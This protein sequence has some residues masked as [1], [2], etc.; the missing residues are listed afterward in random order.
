MDAKS[1]EVGPNGPV[2]NDQKQQARHLVHWFQSEGRPFIE[3]YSP[4]QLPPLD[5]DL[6]RLENLLQTPETITVCFLGHSGVGKS[7]LL[8]ALAAG[9]DFILPA[10]GIGPLTALAT[11]VNYS[12]SPSF[13]VRYHKRGRL[14]RV[15]FAL[16]RTQEA[17][18]DAK[19]SDIPLEEL[20]EETRRELQNEI[21]AS[22]AAEQSQS[23]AN[24]YLKQAQ[25]IVTGD[26]FSNRPAE[27]LIDALRMAGGYKTKWGSA[28]EEGDSKR[29]DRVREALD[30]SEKDIPYERHEDQNHSSFAADLK[31][32][33]AGFLA[34]LIETIQVG[35]PADILKSGVILVDLPGVGIAKDSYRQ[36][37]QSYIRINARA[38]VLT[39]DKSGPTADAVELLRT[40]GYW[41]RLVGA[42]DDPNSDPCKLLIAVTKVDDVASAA[43]LDSSHV[44]P[45]IRPRKRDLYAQLVKDFKVGMKAQVADQLGGIAG[46][47]NLALEEARGKARE[48]ILENLEI[49]PIS[50][51]EYRKLLLD[52]ED[53]RPFLKSTEDTGIIELRRRLVHIAHEERHKLHIDIATVVD[54]LRE[55]ISGELKRLE[56]LWRNR[57][58]AAAITEALE[59][60]LEAFL[61]EKK[62]ERDVRLGGFREFL[63]TTS[64]T[65]IRYLV[66]QA[67]EAAEEDVNAFLKTLRNAHWATLR[68]AVTR[69]GTFVGSRAINLPE[70]IAQRF[71]EP[72]AGVWSTKLLK[73][74]RSRTAAHASDLAVLVSEICDWARSK[75]NSNSQAELIE[76][77]RERI[78]RHA[79]QMQQVGKE[80]VNDLRQIVK[81][82]IM[83]AVRKPIR[84]ACEKF[85]EDNEH[86][87]PGVK[88]RILD[89]F[90]GLA[91]QA[92][93]AA[94]AP[95]TKILEDNFLR[96][97]SD[98]KKAFEDWG[99][100]L[101]E[102]A[103]LI[104]Q[105]Q[106]EAIDKKTEQERELVLSQIV[107]LLAADHISAAPLSRSKQ[108]A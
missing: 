55:A 53:D 87:G 2:L 60:E 11:E 22:S 7:T 12:A 83:E 90:D 16:E 13:S 73:E 100:P 52:D 77:Q 27:Y 108:H 38:V 104:L 62:R 15:V 42:V 9:K 24:E 58:Q 28:F 57:A 78:A 1:S 94:E 93:K 45:A 82:R 48:T 30:T 102:T 95:A 46:S 56:T 80:A 101:Q 76:H 49:H 40:S 4:D 20:D 97:R 61:L 79:A 105:R 103:N 39:V 37:T 92:T 84:K 17:A 25:Q 21:S 31:D 96:V 54:R 19:P 75:S 41:D 67:R 88:S 6:R 69:G 44:D 51:P 107:T 34:P 5:N 35:W 65:Q 63:E 36:V 47:S 72:M 59:K 66:S 81:S 18:A 14:W 23:T 32:H 3:K 70:D 71:Q 26:Q 106:A 50:A 10:G 91:K 99:D 64:K 89:L 33:A 74:L 85:V 98:I 86:R 8:N 68:A 29:I 43:Y